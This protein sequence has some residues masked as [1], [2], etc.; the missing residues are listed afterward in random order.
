ME[1]KTCKTCGGSLKKLGNYYVCEFCG[2][3]WESDVADDI[4]AVQRSNAWETLRSGDF[5]KAES[6][7]D[8]IIV[9]DS[10]NYEAYWGKALSAACITYVTDLNENKK[11]PTC[12]NI[13]EESFVENKYVKKAIELAPEKIAEEYKKQAKYIDDIRVEWLEKAKKEP[14]Y[15]VFISYKRQR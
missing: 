2:N 8:E 10:K 3:R 5:E 15:D 11:I 4:N 12:N 1:L 7:F 14:D 13:T 9:K 6:L